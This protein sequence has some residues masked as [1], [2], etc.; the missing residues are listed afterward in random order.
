MGKQCRLLQSR[1]QP[2]SLDAPSH[3][4]MPSSSPS[5]ALYSVQFLASIGDPMHVC[6]VI[7]CLSPGLCLREAGGLAYKEEGPEQHWG[8]AGGSDSSLT[9]AAPSQCDLGPGGPGV[10]HL[11]DET[12]GLPTHRAVQVS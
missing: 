1:G 4:G 11:T 3:P 5:P 10:G 12:L 8:G 9:L 6:E 7:C 2:G